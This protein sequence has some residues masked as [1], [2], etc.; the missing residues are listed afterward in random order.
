M[1]EAFAQF[2]SALP[3]VVRIWVL[4]GIPSCLVIGLIVYRLP[5][6]QAIPL[7]AA[8]VVGSGLPLLGFV[9]ARSRAQPWSWSAF[10]FAVGWFMVL[11]VPG[12]VLGTLAFILARG[13]LEIA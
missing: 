3:S 10:L 12:L 2:K 4:A 1:R 13:L 7:T 9:W 11:L 6:D 5:P 8:F